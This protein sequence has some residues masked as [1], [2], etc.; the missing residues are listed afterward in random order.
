MIENLIWSLWNFDLSYFRLKNMIK[1]AV[2]LLLFDWLQITIILMQLFCNL[3]NLSS[4]NKTN[5]IIDRM[6]TFQH[7]NCQKMCYNNI[8]IYVSKGISSGLDF[9]RWLFD[10][11]KQLKPL[12]QV[13]IAKKKSLW[14]NIKDLIFY[15]NKK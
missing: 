4:S 7:L 11:F 10:E 3:W 15:T 2:L 6:V 5:R 14:K 8:K 12:K 1:I 13:V 9:Q